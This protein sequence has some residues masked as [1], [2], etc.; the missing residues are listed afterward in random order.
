MTNLQK[1][2]KTMELC[3]I[4]GHAGVPGNEITDK[5]AKSAT[6]RQEDLIPFPYQDLF[7]YIYDAILQ[8]W[9]TEWNQK[10]DNLKENKPNT[11]PCK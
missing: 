8:K 2:G 7:P 11:R 6:Q 10:N 1:T 3:W 5:E 4:P 9:N